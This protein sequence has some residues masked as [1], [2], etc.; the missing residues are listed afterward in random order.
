MQDRRRGKDGA[1]EEG[2]ERDWGKEGERW[3]TGVM[4]DGGK[5]GKLH[6]Q[7]GMRNQVKDIEGAWKKG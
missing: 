1:D 2:G 6:R 5:I 7:T 4:G 3:E